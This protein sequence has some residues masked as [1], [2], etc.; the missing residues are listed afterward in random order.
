[1]KIRAIETGCAECHSGNPDPLIEIY[2]FDTVTEAKNH[3]NNQP[4]LTSMIS[5][6]REV[7]W[8]P[9]PQGGEHTVN[10]QGSVWI[11]PPSLDDLKPS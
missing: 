2:E 3:Y 5:G 10:G 1:M 11:L 8:Q 4:W 9:H 6:F 7:D